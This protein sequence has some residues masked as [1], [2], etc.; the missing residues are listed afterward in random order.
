[1]D[2][3]TVHRVFFKI[4]VLKIDNKETLMALAQKIV[5]ELLSHEQC[6]G[7]SID[8][9]PFGYA[10][11]APYGNWIRSGEIPINN[12]KDYQFRYIFYD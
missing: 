1:M 10:D 9:G 5:K 7:V 12:Y 8:F 4:E 3:S 6:H 2:R 11:F